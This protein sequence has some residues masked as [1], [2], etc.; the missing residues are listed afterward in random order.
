MWC[1]ICIYISYFKKELESK[2]QLTKLKIE[3]AEKL[4]HGLG[5]EKA[6]WKHQIKDLTHTYD[7][8]IGDVLLSSSIV[9]YLGAFTFDYRQVYA[10]YFQFV[11][12]VITRVCVLKIWKESFW[13]KCI[14]GY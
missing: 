3:R 13:T 7:H 6:R 1:G 8:I 5:G 2:I 9:A 4:I 10:Y 14:N 12:L 11:Y